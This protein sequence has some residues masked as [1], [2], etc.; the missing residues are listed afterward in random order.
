MTMDNDLLMSIR[1][2]EE[3]APDPAQVFLSLVFQ[4]DVRSNACMDERI[5]SVDDKV[6][7]LSHHCQVMRKTFL[8]FLSQVRDV[9][10]I[11]KTI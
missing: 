5:V 9:T 7:G 8:E 11:E 2:V 10:A 6:L 1:M 4:R 3:L